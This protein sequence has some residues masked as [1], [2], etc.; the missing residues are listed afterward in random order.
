MHAIGALAAGGCAT[1]GWLGWAEPVR[2]WREATG[3]DRIPTQLRPPRRP[4]WDGDDS[5]SLTWLGHAG[6]VLEWQATRIVVDPHESSRCT[7]APRRLEAAAPLAELE[8]VDAVLLSHAHADHLDPSSLEALASVGAVVLPRG[9]ARWIPSA[10]AARTE[11]IEVG[12]GETRSIGALRV[13]VVE[14]RHNGDRR[15]P[16]AS[17]TRAVGYVV[18]DAAGSN[19]IFF[20]GDTG[21]GPHFARIGAR[22]RPRVAVLPIGA[23][24]PRFPLAPYHQSPSEAVRA[25]LDLGVEVVVPSHFGTFTLSLDRPSWALPRFAR[26]A[27]RGGVSWRMPELLGLAREEAPSG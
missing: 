2:G 13:T 23:W 11:L 9:A 1:A 6:F 14:A 5:P 15:H 10:L 25:A 21:Y 27:A 24:L 8:P 19:T 4:L 18:S 3:W 16:F 20:A 7:I 26:A 12:V 22:H 17:A